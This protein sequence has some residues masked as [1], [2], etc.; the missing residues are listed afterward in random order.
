MN[1]GPITPEVAQ[2]LGV[3]KQRIVS[4]GIPPSKLDE[5]INI[6]TW[7]IREFGKKPRLE[8]SL[9]YIAEVIGQF[10]LVSIVEVRDDIT[11]L[12]K[13]LGYLGPYWKVVFSDY[14]ADPGG[15]S[16][17]IAFVYDTR[18]VAFTG[19]ASQAVAP[20]SRV[21]TEYVTEPAWWRPPYSASFRAGSFDFVLIAA[22]IRW[23]DTEKGRIPELKALADWVAVK[24][25]QR[26][27]HD[28]DIV[29]VGDFNIPAIDSPLF[30]AITSGGL[31]MPPN[32]IG[33]HGSD[34]AQGKRY[35][36]I[37]HDPRFTKSFTGQGGVLDFY[38]RDHAPLFPGTAMTK[39][40]FTFQLSDHLPLWLNVNTDVEDERLDQIIDS[41]QTKVA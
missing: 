26:F 23:G 41:A 36:Q 9:H 22:H 37:L 31:Q 35:D 8:A 27:V 32:L 2:G 38:A 13:V 11:D 28:Q 30:Q 18:A 4:A 17:R 19:L 6:A 39:Q 21:G 3:L 33:V 20:R 34:L 7:N 16:E 12:S 24:Q 25:K 10:D 1:H 40:A 15:N 5:T 29:V 14:L